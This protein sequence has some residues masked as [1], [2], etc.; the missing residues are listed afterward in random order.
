MVIVVL[1]GV[2][3]RFIYIQIPRSTSGEELSENEIII[4]QSEISNMI[5]NKFNLKKESL[6][7]LNIVIDNIKKRKQGFFQLLFNFRILINKDKKQIQ[8]LFENLKMDDQKLI[9]SLVKKEIQLS[10]KSINL[11]LMKKLFSYWHVAHLPFAL[12]ML[13]I[14]IVHIAVAIAFGYTWEF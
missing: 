7:D 5:Q 11:D 10:R 3:G 1:S 12:I 9:L 2:I 13:A 4:K 6:I 14:A 8:E